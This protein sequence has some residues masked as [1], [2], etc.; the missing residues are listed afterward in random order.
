MPH[1]RSRPPDS[2]PRDVLS[3]RELGVRKLKVARVAHASSCGPERSYS[4]M[5]REVPDLA[6]LKD[7]FMSGA[8]SS[9]PLHAVGRFATVEHG[10]GRE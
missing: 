9:A 1:D 5:Q 7:Q 3:V 10:Q 2:A 8:M 4:G 6:Q